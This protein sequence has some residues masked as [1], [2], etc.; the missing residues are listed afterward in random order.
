MPVKDVG[1]IGKCSSNRKM[2]GEFD[3][4][5]NLGDVDS[6]LPEYIREGT[7]VQNVWEG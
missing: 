6:K 4:G 1:P 7:L 5:I 3:R 2:Y